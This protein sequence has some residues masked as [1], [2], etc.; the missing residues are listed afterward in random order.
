MA[1]ATKHTFSI[2][3]QHLTLQSDEFIVVPTSIPRLTTLQSLTFCNALRSG[4]ASPWC[5]RQY[6]PRHMSML[7]ALCTLDISLPAAG[8]VFLCI[9]TLPLLAYT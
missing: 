7:T 8:T 2:T 9:Y 5:I 6:F 3:T 4:H 1:N